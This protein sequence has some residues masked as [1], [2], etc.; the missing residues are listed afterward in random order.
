MQEKK[1]VVYK[2]SAGSGKTHTLVKEY[3]KQVFAEPSNYRK[4]LAITFTNKAANEMKQRIINNLTEIA[5]PSKY[6]G[7]NAVKFMLPD[8]LKETGI[9]ET[10]IIQRASQIL[11][12]ILHNYSDF[13]ISTIDSFMH[14]IIRSFAFDLKLP[15]NFEVE[16]DSDELI[17]KIIDLL[18]DKIGFDE[19]LTRTL[20]EFTKSKTDDEKSWN[21][22]KELKEFAKFLLQEDSQKNIPKLKKLNLSDFSAIFQKIKKFNSW[23]EQTIKIE[24]RKAVEHIH[25]NRIPDEAFFQGTRGIGT[26]FK[27]LAEGRMDKLDPNSYIL[28]TVEEDKWTSGKADTNLIK[29]IDNIKAELLKCFESILEHKNKFF[30]KYL[31]FNEIKKNLYPLALLNEI[32]KVMDE[33]KSD[34][35]ILLIAEFNKRIAEI[36]MNEPVPFI[37]ERTGEKYKHFLLDEFQDT[38]ELQWQNLVPLLDNSLSEGHFNMIVGDGKQAIYRWRNGDVEQFARL[39]DIYRDKSNT[40]FLQ[41]EQNFAQHFQENVLKKNFRS[42]SRIVEFNNSFFSF[43]KG[44]LSDLYQE[45]YTDVEQEPSNKGVDGYVRISFME[46]TDKDEFETRTLENIKSVINNCNTNE[47]NYQDIAVLCRDNKKASKVAAFLLQNGIQVVS[48]ESLLLVNSPEVRFMISNLKYLA[49]RED[50]IAKTEIILYLLRKKGK[51]EQFYRLILNIRFEGN[52]GNDKKISFLQWVKSEGFNLNPDYLASLT[53]FD[54]CEELIRI[55]KLDQ[56]ANPYLQFFLDA[57]LNISGENISDPIDVIDWWE[58][59][60]SKLSLIVPEGM[61]AVSVMT[62]H[63][64]KGLEFPV[65]I[66]PFAVEQHRNTKAKLWLELNEIEEIPDLPVALVN[67]QKN[68][69]ETDYAD[70]FTEESDKSLL[71]MLNLLYVVLTRPTDRLYVFSVVPSDKEDAKTSVPQLLKS[72]LVQKGM[73]EEGKIDYEFGSESDKTGSQ[74]IISKSFQLEKFIS[75]TW[76]NRIALSYRAPEHWNVDEPEQKQEWGT[77]IHTI[78]AKIKVTDDLE[79]VLRQMWSDGLISKEEKLVISEQLMNFLNKTEIG[80]F[81]EK[82]LQVKSEVE[83]ISKKGESFRP[84]RVILDGISATI[85]DFKTGQQE[86]KHFDQVKYY[87]KQLEQVGYN[88]VKCVLLYVFSENPVHR[89]ND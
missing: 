70:Q 33:Y 84:D 21:I 50:A 35:N 8:L 82:G 54:L 36:V 4:I 5:E 55:Y 32:E 64:A 27:N 13:A 79:P 71:D 37:Y 9:D 73:W 24:A 88:P 29:S 10:T 2:S 15:I 86:S 41:R 51:E 39:P 85:I 14:R 89:V 44:F 74:K 58:E 72:Y 45:I 28:K 22:D 87:K 60:K 43:A 7:S 83:L 61:N 67:A 78:L 59:N 48:F 56:T 12:L 46:K 75:N 26:Y 38:S 16:V 65:V 69:L 34:N 47:F 31:I 80:P 3:L 17:E 42:K 25:V 1:F 18:M 52:S 53:L 23:F 11:R 57:M 20:I 19:D 30:K 66:Y 6:Q 49:N 62:I 63:K 77:L 76:R 40:L 68:L 81:F